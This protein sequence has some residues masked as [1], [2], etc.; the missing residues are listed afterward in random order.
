MNK[1]GFELSFGFIFSII[2]IVAII[3]TGFYALGKFL[4]VRNCAEA[5]LFYDDM[6]KEIDRAWNSEI[7]K[8]TASLSAPSE[9]EKVCLG[10][11]HSS[12]NIPEYDDLRT[13]GNLDSNVFLYPSKKACDGLSNKKIEHLEFDYLGVKCFPLV[14][15]RV[16]IR[17]EKESTDS[18]VRVIG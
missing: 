12:S 16:E 7:T 17:I 6:Q 3:F 18:L 10:D 13:Y 4:D 9:I 8:N 11:I 1:R 15:G 2:L 5:G 14:S